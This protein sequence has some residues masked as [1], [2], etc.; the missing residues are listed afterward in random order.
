MRS[1]EYPCRKGHLMKKPKISVIIPIYKVE[2]YIDRC[3]NS[4]RN[5]TF[6]DIEIL[7]VDDCSPDNSYRIVE[8]HAI[9]DPR[10]HLIRHTKNLGLGGARNTAL[11]VASADYIA[12]VDSDDFM[13]PN[14]LQRLWEETDNGWFD[15]VTCGFN[16]VDE[17][18]NIIAF[19]NYPV[20]TLINDDNDINIFSALNPA[21]W[22]KL[23]RKSLFTDNDIFFPLRLYFED[24]PTTPRLLSKAKY[25]KVIE[26]RLYQYFIRE[27]SITTSYSA[28]HII[29]YYHGFEVL[30]RFL[31]DNK[32][33]NRYKDDFIEYINSNMRFHSDNVIS[34]N[35]EKAD[36]EQYLRHLL[37]FKIAFLENRELLKHKNLGDL[38]ILLKQR[39]VPS[40]LEQ[41]K[42]EIAEIEKE[43]YKTKEEHQKLLNRK[44]QEATKLQNLLTD[45]EKEATKLQNLLTDKEQATINYHKS[46][47]RKKQEISKLQLEISK[48]IEKYRIFKQEKTEEILCIQKIGVTIFG[49]FIRPFCTKNQYFKLKKM[50]RRFFKD[51][52][53]SVAKFIGS[54]LGVI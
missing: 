17:K 7:C 13:L 52:K 47:E 2:K 25:I 20:I 50:P 18:G 33:L 39:T 23:W 54:I 11:R 38:L 40:A 32:I 49:I 24:M 51:S 1:L 10:I 19:Q 45:K 37:M 12:S 5:Q 4:V 35:M 46:L 41:K 22:N 29:D 15:I 53:N 16:R 8:K 9:K 26:D 44:K 30:L 48:Y 6:Q 34:S 28:K 3:I 27:E 36:L 21:F 14:M 43:K 31:E 42:K